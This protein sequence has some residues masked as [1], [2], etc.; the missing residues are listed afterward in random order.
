MPPNT[1]VGPPEEDPTTNTH[2]SPATGLNAAVKCSGADE[3]NGYA[4]AFRHY[5]DKGWPS[6]LKLDRGAKYPP[7]S[8]YTGR[9]NERVYP[10]A[11]VMEDWARKEPRG[12]LARLLRGDG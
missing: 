2:T 1:E 3:L 8:S 5:L 6:V 7:P 9:K 12:N 4:D 11:E 10:S